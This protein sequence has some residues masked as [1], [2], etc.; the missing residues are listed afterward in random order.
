MEH[1]KS[2]KLAKIEIVLPR[3]TKR[4]PR[5]FAVSIWEVILD[6]FL[7]VI[8]QFGITNGVREGEPGRTRKEEGSKT[9]RANKR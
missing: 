2:D 9:G 4:V 1:P 3:G 7:Y 6:D 5:R 8:Q